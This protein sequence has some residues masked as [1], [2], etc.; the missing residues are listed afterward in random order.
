MRRFCYIYM[1]FTS[2]L[3]AQFD[4][5]ARM[6]GLSSAYTT[7][8]SGYQSIGV[9]PANLG[10]NKS[11]SANLFSFNGF[12]VNDF[13]SLKLY[14]DINGADFEYS[15][16]GSSAYFPKEEFLSYVQGDEIQIEGGF[17][18]PLPGF[19]FAFRNLFK[20]LS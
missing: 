15:A 16:Q 13:M 3:L 7:V 9:N 2:T 5:D 17:I 1:F 14:N 18:V 10:G 19:N 11:I 4:L 20:F 8:A 6:L 12:M